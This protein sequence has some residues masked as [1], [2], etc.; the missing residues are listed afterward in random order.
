[1]TPTFNSDR[2]MAFDIIYYQYEA[3][4]DC[5]STE[6]SIPLAPVL[7]FRTSEFLHWRTETTR[8]VRRLTRSDARNKNGARGNAL[9]ARDRVLDVATPHARHH[10]PIKFLFTG[11]G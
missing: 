11:L 6:T 10:R 9:P 2:W 3:K 5:P 8:T 1:M 7:P 4:N